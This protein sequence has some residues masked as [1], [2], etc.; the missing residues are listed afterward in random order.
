MSDLMLSHFSDKRLS[1]DSLVALEQ[2][3]ARFK[4]RGFWVSVDGPDDW[5]GWCTS[6][7]FRLERLAIRHRVTVTDAANILRM[8]CGAE[9]DDFTRRYAGEWDSFRGNKIDWPKV[10]GDYDGIIIAPYVWSC[11]LDGP[12]SGWYY[13]WDCASGCIW[14]L[15]AIASIEVTVD[16]Q[17]EAA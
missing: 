4:P 14:N 11:R 17:R 9:L 2:D 5:E 13:S 3:A 6:E 12:S 8:S 1:L 7:G 10:A 15:D 16:L